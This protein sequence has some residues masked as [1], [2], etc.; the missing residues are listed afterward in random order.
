MSKSRILSI[1]G[2]VLA[3]V[4]LGAVIAG[5]AMLEL[6]IAPKGAGYH[7]K[8][9]CSA[10]LVG[11]H[12][13]ARVLREDLG[14]LW[15]V[16]GSVD[17]ETQRVTSSMFGFGRTT[18]VYRP[19]LGCT[20]VRGTDA[21]ALQADV[22]DLPPPRA[23]RSLPWPTGDAAPP[24]PEEGYDLPAIEAALDEA[25]SEPGPTPRRT[26]AIVILHR[27]ELIA[28]RYAEGIDKDTPLVGWS[29]TKSVTAAMIGAAALRGE[30]DVHAPA[31]VPE[32][33]G[34]A[35]QSITLD[36]LLRMS[37]GLHF[38]E[39]YGAFGDATAMLFIAPNAASYAADQPMV[40]EPD[41]RFNY[42]S[43]TTNLLQRIL[44]DELGQESYY[45]L[46][47]E[48]LFDPIGMESA[49]IEPDASGV[50]VG[51][52]FMLA[53]ARDWA[54]FGQLHLQDGVWEGQRLL[55]LGWSRYIATPTPPAE[56]GQYGAQ[57]WLNA[58]KPPGSAD[59]RYPDLPTDLYECSGFEMQKVTVIPSREVVIVR[60]GQT[61][62]RSQWDM[63]AFAGKVLDA[64][65]R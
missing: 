11:G 62:D 23:T 59:R 9:L 15:Y 45:R 57:W 40:A 43:G 48:A 38:D 3:L 17:A 5:A 35:R 64:L 16:Q 27:G 49:I 26:R 47:R 8:M 58:G 21:D 61:I 18:S 63:N 55:P 4:V 32:W 20:V 52:S 14:R 7:S 42:S 44:R 10:V 34:D 25:F 54:R 29:M 13:E 65:P 51:S 31:P 28:E 24:P 36:H 22:P 1:V 30:L 41:S 50:F 60:L 2:V 39:T 33:R 56:K 6:V 12:P 53:T 19:G 46:P 37:S